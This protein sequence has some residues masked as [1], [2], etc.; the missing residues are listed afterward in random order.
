MGA[1]SG[2]KLVD[3]AEAVELFFDYIVNDG[4]ETK[5]AA[6]NAI[7]EYELNQKEGRR[8]FQKLVYRV[9]LARTVVD[10]IGKNYKITEDGGSFDGA[11]RLYRDSSP[12]EL[13]FDDAKLERFAIQFYTNEPFELDYGGNV[14]AGFPYFERA[15][16]KAITK[17]QSG[18]YD[19]LYEILG[20][21][22][23]IY[24]RNISDFHKDRGEDPLTAFLHACSTENHELK[25]IID[26]L[27]FENE[28][29][30]IFI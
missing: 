30:R 3:Q 20:L 6:A 24:Y 23:F 9:D 16:P 12:G 7:S 1:Y 11:E 19:N 28:N 15:L 18:K 17:L 2:E 21:L 25:H 29:H 27:I 26:K 22:M 14:F 4:I 13:K 10:L 8:I 5:V